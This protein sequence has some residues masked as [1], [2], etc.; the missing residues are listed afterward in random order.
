MHLFCLK[1]YAMKVLIVYGSMH[2]HTLKIVDFLKCTAERLNH[3]VTVIEA[4]SSAK[5]PENFDCVIVASAIHAG[6]YIP[7]VIDYVAK[8]SMLLNLIPSAFLSISLSVINKAGK[9][10]EELQSITRFFLELTKWKPLQLEQVA[11]ALLYTKYGFWKKF[12][13][14]SVMKK[15]GGDIDTTRDYEYTNWDLLEKKA[16]AFLH[17]CEVVLVGEYNVHATS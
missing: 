7:A 8:Y 12:L 14:R 15:A 17:Q 6:Q 5:S 4:S 13:V 10:Q 3:T 2:G 9:A 1:V 16:I 11:G